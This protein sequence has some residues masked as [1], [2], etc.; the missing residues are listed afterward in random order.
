MRYFPE[1]ISTSEQSADTQTKNIP[2]Q[3]DSPVYGQ[4][5]SNENA[6]PFVLFMVLNPVNFVKYVQVAAPRVGPQLHRT[7]AWN[8]VDV[9]GNENE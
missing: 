8:D 1:Q 6:F 7:K 2:I 9:R 4:S 5:A 3:Y